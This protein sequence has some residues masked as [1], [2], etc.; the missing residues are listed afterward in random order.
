MYKGKLFGKTTIATIAYLGGVPALPEPF[1]H[2]WTDMIQYNNDYLVEPNQRIYYTRATVSYH[3][4]ARN[5]LVDGMQGDWMLMMDIDHQF[6][7][8]IAARMLNMMNKHDIDVMVA[9]YLY[10]SEPHPPVLY[11]Y[12]PKTKH[13]FIIGD[14][15]KDVE[16]IQIHS[17]G[18]GCLMVRRKVF[19]KIK[20]KLKQSAFDI[21]NHK[22]AMLSEDHSFFERLHKLKIPTFF[23]PQIEFPHLVYKKLTIEEDYDRT[24]LKIKRESNVKGFKTLT[25]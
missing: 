24:G 3:S 21:Y 7:P 8:D 13:K 17:A 1:V 10:K 22:G 19:Q 12:N 14:W 5:S 23:S 2:S 20:E 6:E 15:K 4:F 25:K 11:G 9:P 18:A 16:L